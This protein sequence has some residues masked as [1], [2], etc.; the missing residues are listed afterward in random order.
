[1]PVDQYEAGVSVGGVQQLIGNVW[2]W[3]AEDYLLDGDTG[4]ETAHA[5]MKGI[6][7]GAFDTYLDAQATC[8]FQSGDLALARKH[9][10]GFRCAISWD[11]LAPPV[12]ETDEQASAL[13]HVEPSFEETYS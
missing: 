10:V 2:E 13:H 6:R 9:N 11:D 1:V 3:M 7:G 8:H 4:P 12:S 5:I